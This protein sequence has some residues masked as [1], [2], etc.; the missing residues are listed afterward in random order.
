MGGTS[1]KLSKH[2]TKFNGHEPYDSRD[3][4]YLVCQVNLETMWSTDLTIIWKEAP[5]CM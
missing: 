1:L 4:T 3:I 5:H 2:L